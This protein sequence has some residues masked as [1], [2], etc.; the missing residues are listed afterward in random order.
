M[1]KRQLDLQMTH[2]MVWQVYICKY[3][4]KLFQHI[5]QSSHMNYN[6]NTC[7]LFAYSNLVL[8][9]EIIN[10]KKNQSEKLF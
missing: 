9:S 7:Y 3:I 8:L 4:I 1:K 10:Q 6:I 5:L 2:I